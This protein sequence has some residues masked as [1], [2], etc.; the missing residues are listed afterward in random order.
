MP[1]PKYN[2]LYP[3]VLKVLSD[4]NEYSTRSMDNIIIPTLNLTEEE[5][6]ERLSSGGKVIKNRLG[7]ARTYLKKAGLIES[8]KKGYANI[9]EEGL[10]A[11]K[12]NPNITEEYLMRYPDFV[13]FVT[14]QWPDYIKPP[15]DEPK[16]V[17]T[18]DKKN[19][20]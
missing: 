20:S 11:F 8:R 18:S 5:L 3:N 2:E 10:K 1:I 4:G 15:T 6:E 19:E 7:W 12:E 16:G 9:T 14:G 17:F 13:Y